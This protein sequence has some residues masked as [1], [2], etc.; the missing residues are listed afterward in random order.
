MPVISARA[1]LSGAEGDI[2]AAA[3]V[4]LPSYSARARLAGAEGEIAALIWAPDALAIVGLV[5]AEGSIGAVG[6]S[7]FSAAVPVEARIYYACDLIA[8]GLPPLRVAISSWQATAQTEQ[9]SYAQVVIPGALGLL[10]Q[11]QDYAAADGEFIVYRGAALPGDVNAEAPLVRSPM[12][13]LRFQRGP[14]NAT[15]TIAGYTQLPT[16]GVVQ[17][18]A[19]QNI[20]SL[21]TEPGRRIRCDIDWFLAPGFTAAAMGGEFVVGWINYYA[22]TQDAFMDVG[23]QVL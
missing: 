14:T 23:E 20:R 2:T 21:T 3:S 15:L 12:Q 16:P 17:V 11:I 7:D 1:L 18:R 19:L 9:A 5:G 22:N 4:D 8:S 13:T 10:G 6:I